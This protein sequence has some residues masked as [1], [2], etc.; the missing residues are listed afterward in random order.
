MLNGYVIALIVFLAY[1]GL[2]YVLN[3][4]KWL[5]RHSMSLQG[6][7][8]MWRTRRGKAFIERLASKKRFWSWYG[9]IALWIC[10]LSMMAIMVL[11][12]WEATIVPQIKTAPSPQLVLGIPGINPIIPIWYG[13]L[14]LLV[15]IVVHE[16][17][18]GILTRAG[19]MKVQSLGLVFLVFPIGAFVEPDE[20]DLQGATRSKRAKVY[21][22]GPGTNIVLSLVMLSLFSGVFM[23]S[24]EPTHEGALISV[25]TGG[26][27]MGSPAER[28]GL[29]ANC[30]VVS[31]D[32]T[33]ISSATDL[34]S[35]ISPHPG[36]LVNVSYYYAGKLHSVNMADG[37][38]VAFTTNGFAAANASLETG[39]ILTSLNG[40][41]ITGDSVL[42]SVM[43]GT[44][45]GQTINLTAMSY[46]SSTEMFAVNSSISTITLSDKFHYYEKFD[47]THNS[48]DYHGVGFLG[49]GFSNLGMQ[50]E[51]AS[52]YKETLATPFKGDSSFTDYSFSALRLIA[53]PFLHLAPLR[54]PVTDIYHPVG[55]LS[56]MPDSA[57]WILANSLYWIFWLNLMV[58]LTNVL[59]AVPLDGGYLFR[60]FMDYLLSKTGKIYTKEQRD[61]IVGNV[62]LALALVVLGLILWQLVGPALNH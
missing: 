56:W 45:A 15:A 5:E 46:D 51:N 37:L 42:K 50:V 17:A 26:V 34:N 22:V 58:G 6:P 7:L 31:I 39:M 52:F 29:S 48:P 38:V 60:D 19:G 40:T 13:I 47:P 24:L 12:I 8:L 1:I 16:F 61:K 44:H 32:G 21:A 49:A 59:P 10:L 28:S 23:S 2:I 62:V 36:A 43:A 20:K 4:T 11:L 55:A 18:H 35:R 14:G 54:T 41:A 25:T 33:P 3:R 53:L 30:V 27:V 9:R 57:F